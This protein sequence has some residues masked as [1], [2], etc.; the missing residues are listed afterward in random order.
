MFREKDQ[1]RLSY[2]KRPLQL[3]V[4]HWNISVLCTIC[5]LYTMYI[6]KIYLMVAKTSKKKSTIIKCMKQEKDAF[7]TKLQILYIH[8]L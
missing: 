3:H 1:K 5:L 8:V 4:E 6:T 7:I 2:L